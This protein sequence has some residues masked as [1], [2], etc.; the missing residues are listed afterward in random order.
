MKLLSIFI[1]TL[2]LSACGAVNDKYDG[3]IV[4]DGSGNKYQLKHNVMD[5]YFIRE[6]PKNNNNPDWIQDANSKIEG[7]VK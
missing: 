2:A 5:T 6:V 4:I 3:L 1:I 7:K